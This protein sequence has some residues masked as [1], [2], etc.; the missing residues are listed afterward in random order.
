VAKPTTVTD[1]NTL[2]ATIRHAAAGRPGL[3]LT[4]A[5]DASGEVLVAV[6]METGRMFT[7][8]P[9]SGGRGSLAPVFGMHGRRE[10]DPRAA[11]NVAVYG[12]LPAPEMDAPGPLKGL[13]GMRETSHHLARGT[14][15]GEA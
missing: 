9:S 1:L 8:S 4:I 11:G 12:A 15:A 6:R 13:R 3:Q 2:L 14:Y 5:D 7:P 10:S